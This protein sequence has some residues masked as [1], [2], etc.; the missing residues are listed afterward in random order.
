MRMGRAEG[1]WARGVFGGAC[2]H[3]EGHAGE[4]AQRER[5]LAPSGLEQC[6]QLLGDGEGSRENDGEDGGG[7]RPRL[8]VG[9]RANPRLG[10][11]VRLG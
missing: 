4:P 8:K 7:A 10:T 6:N 9:L 2:P 11:K 5:H 3:R 1:G